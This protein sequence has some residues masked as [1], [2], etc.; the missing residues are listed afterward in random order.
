MS[1]LQRVSA[2]W[3]VRLRVIPLYSSIFLSYDARHC[4]YITQISLYFKSPN[5]RTIK[6]RKPSRKL[7]STVCRTEPIW[8]RSPRR[9]IATK[10]S[11]RNTTVTVGGSGWNA[12]TAT[13]LGWMA[14]TCDRSFGR[15]VSPMMVMTVLLCLGLRDGVLRAATNAGITFASIKVFIFFL[16][17]RWK[18]HLMLINDFS[19]FASLGRGLEFIYLSYVL[20]HFGGRYFYAL[21]MYPL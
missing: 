20:R 16:V 3:C 9:K 4:H 1:S 12:L 11:V 13:S 8:C 21:E 19:I 10:S 14:T 18:H 6:P 5:T 15:G 17:C 2:L 7:A